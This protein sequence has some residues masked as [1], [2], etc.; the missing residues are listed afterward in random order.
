MEQTAVDLTDLPL[1]PRTFLAWG[2]GGV[3][4]QAP[5]QGKLER[6]F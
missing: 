4:L 5:R 6:W 2:E 1:G 3:G